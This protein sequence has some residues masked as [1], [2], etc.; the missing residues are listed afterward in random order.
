MATPGAP[1]PTPIGLDILLPLEHCCPDCIPALI[2]I[3]SACLHAVH[4]A[5][6]QV[7]LNVNRLT[8]SLISSSLRLAITCEA[9]VVICSF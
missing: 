2:T 3:H 7:L 6:G 4:I 1:S 9:Q 5:T 8:V